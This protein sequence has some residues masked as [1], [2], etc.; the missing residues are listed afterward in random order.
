MPIEV[1]LPDGRIAEF[2]DGTSRAVIKRALQRQFG[3]QPRRIEGTEAQQRRAAFGRQRGTRTAPPSALETVQT[4]GRGADDL[5]RL[6]ARGATFGAADRIAGALPGGG[7]DFQQQRVRTEQAQQ[8]TGAAGT[9]AEIAGSTATLGGIFGVASR[10][11]PAVTSRFLPATATGAGIGA[12]ETEIRTR[13]DEGRAPTTG[14]RLTGAAFGGAGGG[15]ANVVGRL[16]SA[17]MQKLL[18]SGPQTPAASQLREQANLLYSQMREAGVR[19]QPRQFENAVEK[20]ESAVKEAGFRERTHPGIANMLRDL[21]ADA[22]RYRKAGGV[23]LEEVE[24]IRRVIRDLGASPTEQRLAGVANRELKSWLDHLPDEGAGTLKQARALQH[25]VF[26]VE[27]IERA[28][29][30]A[31]LA[32]AR[33]LPALK[34]AFRRIAK[35]PDFEHT[36]NAA[37]RRAIEKVVKA[38]AFDE[39]L[40]DTRS[41]MGLLGVGSLTFAFGGPTLAGALALGGLAGEKAVAGTASR[42][43]LEARHLIATGG[44]LPGPAARPGAATFGQVMG[45]EAQGRFNR[46]GRR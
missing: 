46:E 40:R 38:D 37:E 22:T 14:E 17:G 19:I 33:S 36:F 24:G 13:A 34:G 23:D 12:A 4:I 42:R 5:V 2:P 1:E 10:A 15:V 43:A 30:D 26:K 7:G 32:A 9:A 3:R 8:R 45:L 31:D 20:V 35:R 28:L 29:Q 18:G 25:R 11:V 6:A 27:T 21:K 16:A 44:Q 41:L 39:A